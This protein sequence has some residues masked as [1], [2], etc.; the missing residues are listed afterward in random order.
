MIFGWMVAGQATAGPA[1]TMAGIAN[2]WYQVG[3]PGPDW[4]DRFATLWPARGVLALSKAGVER[5]SA[6]WPRKRVRLVHPGV[7]L[8]A[9]DSASRLDMRALRG[10]LGLPPEAAIVGIVGRLQRWK[11]MHVFIDAFARIHSAN[12]AVRGVIVGGPHE[13][14]PR[15]AEELREQ[16]DRLGV[17]NSITFAGFQSNPL[18]WM[19]AMDVV[20]HASDREPFGIVIVEA[21][22]LGKPVVAGSEGGPSEIITGGLNGLLSPYGDGGALAEAMTRFLVDPVFARRVGGAARE[23]AREFSDRAYA[24]RVI[25][26][27]RE[28]AAS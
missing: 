15:Y 8:E 19:Q 23:R 9:A 3:T 25:E 13:T 16:A 14:E 6:I 5:Q 27:I 24:A 12:G 21:M 22:A 18:E 20:V 11:G 10:R 4:L 7:S 2:A 17:S 28:F 1:A 26:A